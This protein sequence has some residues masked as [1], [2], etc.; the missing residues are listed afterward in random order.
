L[1]SA[2]TGAL[3]LAGTATGFVK[4]SGPLCVTL[5]VALGGALHSIAVRDHEQRAPGMEGFM[6]ASA[7]G[8]AVQF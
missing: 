5:D 6:L 7:A 1:G 8:V 2:T 3:S 4:V